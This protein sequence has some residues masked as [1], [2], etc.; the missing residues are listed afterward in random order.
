[1]KLAYEH[2]PVLT[3]IDVMLV[4]SLIMYPLYYIT[5]KCM[6]VNLINIKWR[7]VKILIFRCFAGAIGMTMLFMSIKILPT[8]IAF[9]IFNLNPLF[10]T[11]LSFCFLGEKL[12]II[13]ALCVF[14][15]LGGILLVAYGRREDETNDYHQYTG[16]SMC[17]GAAFICSLAIVS[18]KKLNRFIHFIYSPYYLCLASLIICGAFYAYDQSYVNIHTYDYID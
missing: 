4:R 16:I 13:N 1:M 11:I 9:L 15:A 12:R 14:G 17:L 6:G 3:G 7:Y 18:M 5:A 8:S 2:N 10:V